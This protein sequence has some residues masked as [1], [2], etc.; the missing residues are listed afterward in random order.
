MKFHKKAKWLDLILIIVLVFSTV[1]T[2]AA[3]A[4]GGFDE[5]GYNYTANLFNVKYYGY[6]RGASCDHEKKDDYLSI[7]WNDAW[8]DENK[9]Q[10]EGL[11]TYQ[12]SGAW[13]TNHM[14][15]IYKLEGKMCK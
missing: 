12:G 6:L 3:F 14:L 7:K 10:H 5:W 2:T 13:L 1:V 9:V 11:P 4:G 8:L 15:G